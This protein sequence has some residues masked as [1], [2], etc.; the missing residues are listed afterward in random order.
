MYT[1]RAKAIELLNGEYEKMLLKIKKLEEENKMLKK[2]REYDNGKR[3]SIL[4]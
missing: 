1:R 4:S 2:K 3:N